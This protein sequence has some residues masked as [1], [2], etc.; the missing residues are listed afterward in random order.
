MEDAFL[1]LNPE[2]IAALCKA[3]PCSPLPPSPPPSPDN[4]SLPSKGGLA[5]GLCS[6]DSVAPGTREGL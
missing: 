2:P 3:E 5:N 1:H 6:G 4:C